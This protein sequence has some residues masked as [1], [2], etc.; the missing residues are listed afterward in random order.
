M[1]EAAVIVS[2]ALLSHCFCFY[3]RIPRSQV[4]VSFNLYTNAL[5]LLHTGTRFASKY[6]CNCNE[7]VTRIESKQQKYLPKISFT[8]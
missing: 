4:S 3:N 5:T 1:N 6:S 2:F 7:A 8:R